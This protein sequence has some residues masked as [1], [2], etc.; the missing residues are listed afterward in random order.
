[1][2]RRLT[3]TGHGRG[4]KR[5]IATDTLGFLLV[6]VVTAASVQDTTGGL[7]VIDTLAGAHPSVTKAWVDSGYKRSVI[8][9]GAA[10]GIDVEVITKDPEKKGFHPTLRWPVERTLC[11]ARRSVVSP[12]QPG[13]TRREVPGSNGLPGSERLRGQEHARKPGG[14]VQWSG[15]ARRGDPRDMAKAGLPEAQSP[16]DASSHPPERPLKP[17][18]CSA[19]ESL[20]ADA[21]FGARGDAQRGC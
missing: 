10:Q 15:T 14:R 19:S 21:T 8:E 18:P 9:A 16:V 1:V 6:I 4:T 5:H 3:L 12:V 13:G 17:V 2:G 7:P 11:A 20:V